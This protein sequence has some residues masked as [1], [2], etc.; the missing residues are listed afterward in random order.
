MWSV[1]KEKT[2]YYS[3][4]YFIIRGSIVPSLDNAQYY[5]MLEE[6][7]ISQSTYDLLSIGQSI[8]IIL[9]TL[10]YLNFLTKY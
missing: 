9:G 7:K 5:F 3:L 6:C 10:F 1:L 4:L 8:G 2:V